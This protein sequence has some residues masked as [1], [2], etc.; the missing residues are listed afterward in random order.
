MMN[1]YEAKIS[2]ESSDKIFSNN[3]AEQIGQLDINTGFSNIHE[4]LETEI[5]QIQSMVRVMQQRQRFMDIKEGLLE[6]QKGYKADM[7]KIL[8][9][10]TTLTTFFNKDKQTVIK[11]LEAKI[12]E[13]NSKI[14]KVIVLCD[15]ITGI[16]GYVEIDSFKV[17][18]G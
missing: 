8:A 16:L 1:K 6:E 18:S 5:L 10:K 4:M 2:E 11:S 15:I 14:D 17:H 7:Q 12:T 13:S 9:G 3:Y